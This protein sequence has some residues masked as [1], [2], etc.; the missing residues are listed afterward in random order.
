MPKPTLLAS[1]L[2]PAAVEQRARH[3]YTF[4]ANRDDTALSI[5]QLCTLAEGCDA[6]IITPSDR[7]DAA[8]IA[9]LPDRVRIAATFSVGTDHIDLDAARARG[10]VITNTPDVL[11]DAT[12][13]IA[14]LLMLGAA[15][16]AAEGMAMIANN[17][18]P[19]W[20]PTQLV[21]QQLTGKRLGILGMG[22]IGQAVAHRARAFG[23]TIH[24]HNRSR[25]SPDLEAGA[26][27]HADCEALLAVSDVLSLH[28]PATAQ[29]TGFLNAAR[30]ALMPPRAI[31][32]NTARGAVIDEP[33]LRE[34]L[35]T[36][37]IAAAGLDVFVGEPN[38]SRDWCRL[39][40]VILLPHLGSATETTRNAMGF[41]ALDNLDAFFA[42]QQPPHRLP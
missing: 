12:A 27:Y 17:A 22:R 21:G 9:A 24:Y 16:R 2:L 4:R 11:T 7:L 15:R 29:T 10:L 6:L 32:I 42:G 26:I 3:G 35:R 33:A 19:G 5:P 34:A 30:L 20:A 18:W 1:R 40:N 23:M 36:G 41:R 13:E 38:I 28:C 39:S 37:K 25:L 31:V 14:L 8:A